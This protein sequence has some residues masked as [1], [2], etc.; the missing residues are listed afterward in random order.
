MRQEQLEQLLN[1]KQYQ[2]NYNNDQNF[3]LLAIQPAYKQEMDNEV[4]KLEQQS[5]FADS[6]EVDIPS[7]KKYR[8]EKRL[9]KMAKMQQLIQGW[10][11]IN[12]RIK[13]K[14]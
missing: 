5:L 1:L 6:I 11:G 3:E 10:F 9:R 2:M 8:V 7:L 14:L 12:R 13:M 4:Q